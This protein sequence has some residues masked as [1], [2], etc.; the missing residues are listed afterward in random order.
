MIPAR[1]SS[2]LYAV[3]RIV[4]GFL[5]LAHGLQKMFGL[6]EGNVAPFGSLR[7]VAGVVEVVTGPLIVF[8]LFTRPAAFIASGQM[9]F[10]YFITH[11]PRAFWPIQNNG[12]PAA[13]LCFAFLYFASQG[14]GPWS[15]GGL[16]RTRRTGPA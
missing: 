12:E 4:F 2:H 3:M 15:L 1:Y 5:Y 6:F 13:L 7:A 16:P 11:F 10:A 8:G 14:D 9:A